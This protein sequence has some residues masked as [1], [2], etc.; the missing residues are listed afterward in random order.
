M[1]SWVIYILR[2]PLSLF[3]QQP[4]QVNFLSVTLALS[5]YMTENKVR[6]GSKKSGSV[7]LQ[8]TNNFFVSKSENIITLV[9][10]RYF[11]PSVARMSS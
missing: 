6:N 1:F 3:F 10:L 7:K 5:L 9:V 8:R 4:L 2:N 11:P